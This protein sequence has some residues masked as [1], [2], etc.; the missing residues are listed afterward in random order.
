MVWA[1]KPYLVT[2]PSRQPSRVL[3]DARALKRKAKLF[4][5]RE[6]TYNKRL[7]RAAKRR[8][9][10]DGL[11]FSLTPDDVVVPKVCPVL[12]IPIRMATGTSNYNSAS[13][14]RIDNRRGYTPDN[15][16]VVSLRAN[17]LKRDASLD[18]LQL[19]AKFYSRWFK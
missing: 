14:D 10:R 5:S 4:A 7:L 8:A 19:L 6:R 9:E 18:E 17:L 15:I 3:P 13:I 11:E 12:G 1:P 2:N 16:V